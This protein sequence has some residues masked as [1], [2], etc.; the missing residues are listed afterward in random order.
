MKNFVDQDDFNGKKKN[1]GI[2]REGESKGR[3]EKKYKLG[4]LEGRMGGKES[5]GGGVKVGKVM[6]IGGMQ[7]HTLLGL[8]LVDYIFH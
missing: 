1:E 3:D 8:G 2:G 7:T 4:L 6:E 5:M